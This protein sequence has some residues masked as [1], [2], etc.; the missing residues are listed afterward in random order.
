MSHVLTEIYIL[1]WNAYSGDN[2]YESNSTSAKF[3]V[4]KITPTISLEIVD[5]LDGEIE[6]INVTVNA[7]GTV[8]ITV[9]GIT[10]EIPLDDGVKTTDVLAAANSYDGKASRKLI[11]LAKGKYSVYAAY[12]A[13]ENYTSVNASDVFHVRGEIEDVEV[14]IGDVSVGETA[15]IEVK[16]P[17]DATGNLTITVDGKTYT[18]PLE[19]GSAVFEVPNLKAGQHEVDVSYSGDDKYL[20]NDVNKSF[21]VSKV[22]PSINVNIPDVASGKNAKVTV[23]LPEDATW[24]VTLEIGGKYYSAQVKDGKAV[25]NIPNLKAG[26]YNI[27]VHYS[28]DD[29]YLEEYAYDVVSV[30]FNENGNSD[31]TNDVKHES[32]EG[33]AKYPTAN[34]IF[35]LMLAILAM[36]STQIRRFKKE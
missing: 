30:D 14:D 7:P 27:A 3:N 10:V 12:N 9:N 13:N 4:A 8:N 6:V 29:Q 2:E 21:E 23:T 25:F 35:V 26:D 31:D 33:L 16:Y 18:K 15:R 17:E 34:P 1:S 22:N 20:P 28:G 36:G 11:N 19:N 24:T 5:I 32:H